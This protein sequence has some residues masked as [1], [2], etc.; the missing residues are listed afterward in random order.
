MSDLRRLHG[1]EPRK[2]GDAST[3]LV[4]TKFGVEGTCGG[5]EDLYRHCSPKGKGAKRLRE[6]RYADG[7]G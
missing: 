3:T 7:S 2:L 6:W 5:W 1:S 4:E